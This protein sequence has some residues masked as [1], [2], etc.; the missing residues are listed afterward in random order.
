MLFKGSILMHVP[1]IFSKTGVVRTP[2]T[3][4]V[5]KYNPVTLV[6]IIVY[7][8]M[9]TRG[10][11]TGVFGVVLTT[12]VFEKIKGTCIKMLHLNNILTP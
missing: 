9:M 5:T 1:F 2:P 11:V 4:P 6:K 10:V 7:S 12:P 8:F 3:T